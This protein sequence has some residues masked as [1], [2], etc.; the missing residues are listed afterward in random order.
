MVKFFMVMKF[1]TGNWTVRKDNRIVRKSKNQIDHPVTVFRDQNLIAGESVL[2]FERPGRNDGD[3]VNPF[4]KPEMIAGNLKK[5]F[6]RD[7][8]SK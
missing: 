4:G 2:I 8:K 1:A 3:S 6:P 7:K 5:Y